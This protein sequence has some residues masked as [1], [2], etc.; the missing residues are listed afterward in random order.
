MY[1]IQSLSCL[2]KKINLIYLSRSFY[3]SIFET[4]SIPIYLSVYIAFKVLNDSHVRKLFWSYE[5][6]RVSIL[7]I[8]LGPN[9]ASDM[10]FYH[11]P[12]FVSIRNI[13]LLSLCSH[14]CFRNKAL[15]I[16]IFLIDYL[17]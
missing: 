10:N 15:F 2:E 12:K 4:L 8:Q 5:A 7:L 9:I 11:I 17:G 1:T 16:S 14:M 6:D 13:F 3:L